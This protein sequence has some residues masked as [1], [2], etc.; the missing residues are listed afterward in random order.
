MFKKLIKIFSK[1]RPEPME[2]KEE[3]VSEKVSF[4]EPY[5]IKEAFEKSNSL[6]EFIKEIDANKS[7]I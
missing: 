2:R 5:T 3:K 6:S 4:C 7:N 1:K